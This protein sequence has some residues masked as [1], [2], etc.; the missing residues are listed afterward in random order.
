[1]PIT[2]KGSFANAATGDAPALLGVK[3]TGTDPVAQ[4]IHIGLLM[5]TSGSMEGTRLESV[6]RTISILLS[7]L[8]AGDLITLV[9]FSNK[10]NTVFKME[11][12]D[13]DQGK[14]DAMLA[15]VNAL[16]AE[17]GTNMECGITELGQILSGATK[18]LGALVL[19][20]D[21][22]INEGISSVAGLHSIIKSYLKTVPVYTLG[23]GENHN[24]TLLKAISLRTNA[25]YTYI[26]QEL[27]LP[28]SIGNM[29]GALQT[30][31]ASEVSLGFDSRWSCAEPEAKPGS[32]VF[33][34]GSI[35][36][37]KPMW[38][39]F[40][41]PLGFEGSAMTLSYKMNGADYNVT[42]TPADGQCDILEIEE[43]NLRCSNANTLNKVSEELRMNKLPDA[44]V[45]LLAGLALL[46]A[47]ALVSRPLVIQM[48][49]ELEESLEEVEKAILRRS[50]TTPAS[51]MYRMTSLGGNY[52]GQRG[53]TQMANGRTPGVFSSPDQIQTSQGMT[54]EYSQASPAAHDPDVV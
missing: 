28:T 18:P 11:T 46:N 36:A 30:E 7:R 37:E 50:R 6:K 2:I 41:V 12:I 21:G 43:N 53:V 23:Y 10:A 17:G 44:K 1:M 15:A 49:A 13:V 27:M 4:N 51:L 26:E 35:I 45:L 42:F 3:I 33:E 52:A 9:G 39:I 24:G 14:K 25:S 38:A 19:L 40:R 22:E 54:V 32:S 8:N 16:V 47:S 20:T 5:D 48:K 34:F 31:V 29:L